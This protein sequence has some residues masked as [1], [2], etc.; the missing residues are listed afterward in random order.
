MC[1]GSD[2]SSHGL[3][4]LDFSLISAGK[5]RHTHSSRV[6]AEVQLRPAGTE[7]TEGPGTRGRNNLD[8]GT[9]CKKEK[10]AVGESVRRSAEGIV[11]I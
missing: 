10:R 8:G 5:H 3:R 4:F 2:G 7:G 6:S 9:D 1:V 11:S